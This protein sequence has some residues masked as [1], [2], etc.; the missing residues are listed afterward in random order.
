MAFALQASPFAG[1]PSRT[2]QNYELKGMVM[3]EL[4][5][6]GPVLLPKWIAFTVLAAAFPMWLA[7][8]SILTPAP[9]PARSP[10]R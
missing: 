2:L 3:A 5:A 1:C 8:M 6:F 10:K 7:L 4:V 9:R